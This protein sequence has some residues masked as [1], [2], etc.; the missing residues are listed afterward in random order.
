MASL[1]VKR[2]PARGDVIELQ[3]ERVWVGRGPDSDVLLDNRTVSR[4]HAVLIKRRSGWYVQ[5]LESQNGTLINGEPVVTARLRDGDSIQFG[6]VVLVF[7]EDGESV[8]SI[9]VPGQGQG[10]AMDITQIIR[11]DRIDGVAASQRRGG[12][13]SLREDLRLSH[14]LRLTEVAAA[15]RSVEPLFEA[16]IQGL[17]IALPADLVIPFLLDR[18]NSLRPYLA[19]RQ[20]FLDS[21]TTLGIDCAVLNRCLQEGPL[22]AGKGAPGSSSVACVPMRTG[23]NNRGLIYCQ[24]Q[25]AREPFGDED[26][27]YL[28]SVALSAALALNGLRTYDLMARRTHS[29]ARQIQ[30]QYN[31]VGESEAMHEVFRLIRKVAPSDAGVL[32]HGPS[33]TGKE[34]VAHAIHNNS[35]RSEG[36]LEIVNCAAVPPALL[37]S[38]LF[39]HVRGAFTGAVADK[40]GRFELADGGTLFLDEVAELPLECQAKLLR[41]LEESHVRRVG[42]T[43]TRPVDVRLIAATNRDPRQAQEDGF[44][45]PDLFYRLDRFRIELPPLR[46]RGGDIELLAR[47]FLRRFALQV[48]HPV[49]DFAPEVLQ[50]F[51]SYAWPGNVRELRNVVERMV[52]LADSPVLGV[53][54]VPDDLRASVHSTPPHQSLSEM[55]R[56]HIARVLNATNGNKKQ[57]AEVLG[58]DR[59]TLYAKLKRYG[60]EG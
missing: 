38:E 55:E 4:E 11:L 13:G 27:R 17:Q 26:L 58:I 28:F 52:I 23:V 22:I 34:M 48:K 39:G 59:S 6:N 5:D 46:A 53:E 32:I 47:H 15:A 60:I 14:L 3:G 1:H 25:E 7:R 21:A 41:V 2:G 16:I 20:G 33:G 36:P 18:D 35:R 24:R 45:R 43:R 8:H 44:L 31:M 54:L 9:P 51:A 37:E 57:A 56:E 19:Q 49:H 30:E 29:L 10:R 42:S 12:R 50:M 40:P